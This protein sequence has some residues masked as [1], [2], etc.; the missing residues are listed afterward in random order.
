MQDD[1]IQIYGQGTSFP[2]NMTQHDLLQGHE[3]TNGQ[4][5]SVIS[6]SGAKEQVQRRKIVRRHGTLTRW[7][8]GNYQSSQLLSQTENATG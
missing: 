6:V 5:N 1:F 8:R 2:H 7:K 3:I 4:R